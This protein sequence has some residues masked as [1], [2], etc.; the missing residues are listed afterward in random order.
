MA[1]ASACAIFF[2]KE[3]PMKTSNFPNSILDV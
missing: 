1:P 3:I 2:W